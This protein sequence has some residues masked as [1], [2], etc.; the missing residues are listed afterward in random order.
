MSELR[1]GDHFHGYLVERELGRGGMGVVYL[2]LEERLGRRVAL[3]VLL[4]S[5]SA[6]PAFRARFEREARIAASLEH[7]HVVPVYDFGTAGES[8]FIAMRY[9]PGHD[10]ATELRGGRALEPERVAR[11][12]ADVASA[13]DAAHHAGLVHRDVKPAN[14]L[15]T[16]Q[17]DD[18]HAYL[19]D[20]GLTR[21]AASESG[22][23]GTGEWLGTIDYA[24]PEQFS[25]GRVDARTDVYALAC[26]A[27]HGL[28]GRVP[29]GGGTP[30]T[31]HGHLNVEP[32]T[33]SDQVTGLPAQVDAV[34]ARGLAKSPD[35]RH[36][37][38]GDFARDLTAAITGRANTRPQG[39]VATGRALTGIPIAHEAPTVTHAARRTPRPAPAAPPTTAAPASPP[40]RSRTP[41]AIAAAVLLAAAGAGAA[42]LLTGGDDEPAR[43]EARTTTTAD[44][45]TVERVRTQTVERTVTAP[46]TSTEAP[47]PPPETLD[48]APYTPASGTWTAE[49]P[50]GEG[51]QNAGEQ[52]LNPGLLRTAVS[53]P[54]GAQLWIDVTPAEPPG[55]DTGSVEVAS[56]RT[57]AGGIREIVFTGGTSFCDRGTCAL[58]QLRSGPGGAAV[59]GGPTATARAAALRTATSMQLDLG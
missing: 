51:W 13:L 4:P 8:L 32:P 54:D 6:D 43:T 19:S 1:S 15:L 27:F 5:L 56:E 29:Y 50:V 7:P 38:A 41:I 47:A 34:L 58:Y 11:I 45:R 48:F 10:L 31:I 12:V 24:A 35:D 52:E 17:G 26:L 39:P 53:G 36:P 23:T 49:L 44:A 28:V 18:E 2:A 9:V 25:L 3:K 33:A 40:R 22:L 14:V 46:P 20:F 30:A 55:F 37:S 57:L 21:E 16:G 42:V 59:L